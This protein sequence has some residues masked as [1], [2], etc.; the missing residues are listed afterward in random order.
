MMMKNGHK[1]KKFSIHNKFFQQTIR[2]KMYLK[3]GN[4]LEGKISV[5]T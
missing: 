3:M 1:T 2:K 5:I 4:K